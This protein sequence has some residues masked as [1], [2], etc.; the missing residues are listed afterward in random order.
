MIEK[1]TF[2]YFPFGKGFEK[3]IKTVVDQGIKQVEALKVLK[4]EENQE[5][6]STGGRFPK[7]I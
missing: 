4:P 6:E 1:A 2:T 5:P 7:K 3:K